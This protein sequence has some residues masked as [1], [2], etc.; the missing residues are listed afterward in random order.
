MKLDAEDHKAI[1][2]ELAARLT[3]RNPGFVRVDLCEERSGTLKKQVARLQAWVYGLC[4]GIALLVVQ[5][6]AN[7][8]RVGR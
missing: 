2:A 7:L 3:R 4:T 5:A 6:A 8:L 1:A